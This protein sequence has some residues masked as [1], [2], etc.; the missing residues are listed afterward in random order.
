MYGQRNNV[1]HVYFQLAFD[2]FMNEWT[3]GRE[4]AKHRDS[5]CGGR[6]GAIRTVLFETGGR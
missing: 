5:L 1:L 6:L 2:R 4:T 3:H